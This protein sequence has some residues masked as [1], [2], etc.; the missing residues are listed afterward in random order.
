[1]EDREPDRGRSARRPLT[2]VHPSVHDTLRW[3]RLNPIGK[4]IPPGDPR[5]LRVELE[6]FTGDDHC[7]ST[8]K[9]RVFALRAGWAEV[10]HPYVAQKGAASITRSALPAR[11]VSRTRPWC[12]GSIASTGSPQPPGAGATR[13]MECE[14][15]RQVV[16]QFEIRLTYA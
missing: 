2:R 4:G 6:A 9:Q 10:L 7:S 14:T 8:C 13:G 15:E 1:M 11:S 16:G 12:R 3:H 5:F